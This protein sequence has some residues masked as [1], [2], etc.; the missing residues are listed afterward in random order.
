M[1][2]AKMRTSPLLLVVLQR[3]LD[4]VLDSEL[5]S[6]HQLAHPCLGDPLDQIRAHDQSPEALHLGLSGMLCT[7]SLLLQKPDQRKAH[8]HGHLVV[9]ELLLRRSR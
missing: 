3:E 9:P 7:L 6:V 4:V 5:S 2:D 1:L 8:Q